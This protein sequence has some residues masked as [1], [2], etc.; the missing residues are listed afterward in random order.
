VL[1]LCEGDEDD[2][3]LLSRACAAHVPRCIGLDANS[4][5]APTRARQLLD[6]AQIQVDE[7]R[8]ELQSLARAVSK[9]DPQRLAEV[10]KHGCRRSTPLARK[11]RVAPTELPAAGIDE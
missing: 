4:A 8:R 5:S 6:S 9:L 10:E 2:G 11:H 7:A 3:G 1:A